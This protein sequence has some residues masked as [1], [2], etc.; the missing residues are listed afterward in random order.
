MLR[1]DSFREIVAQYDST[2]TDC[3]TAGGGHAIKKGD[4]IGYARTHG[5]A[6]THC[7]ACWR[8][9]VAENQYADAVES[10]YMPNCL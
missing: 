1:F 10:G 4:V 3:G 7:A 5:V 6:H 8:K 9:W 2:S